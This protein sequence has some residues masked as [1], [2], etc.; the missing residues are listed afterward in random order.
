MEMHERDVERQNFI[1]VR[2]LSKIVKLKYTKIL[3]ESY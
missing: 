3:N 2:K 1:A